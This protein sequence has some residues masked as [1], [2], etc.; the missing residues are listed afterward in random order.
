MIVRAGRQGRRDEKR[1]RVE[2]E[3]TEKGEVLGEGGEPRGTNNVITTCP[4]HS[5][6]SLVSG[7]ISQQEDTAIHSS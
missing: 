2:I 7:T 5:E 4:K 3:K 1:I 6:Y